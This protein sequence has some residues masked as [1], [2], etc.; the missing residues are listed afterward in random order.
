MHNKSIAA[1][2][3]SLNPRTAIWQNQH[4]VEQEQNA[5]AMPKRKLCLGPSGDFKLLTH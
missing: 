2:S 4:R 1:H 5:M 3:N